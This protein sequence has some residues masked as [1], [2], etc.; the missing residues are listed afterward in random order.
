M[1]GLYFPVFI[2]LSEKRIL[3][4]GGGKVAQRRVETLLAFTPN[5]VVAAPKITAE[6]QRLAGEGAIVWLKE[7]Y[8]PARLEGIDLVLAATDDA[9]CNEQAVYDCRK[10]GIPVNAAHKKELCD[11]YFPAVVRQGGLVA[12]VTSSG[13]SHKKAREAREGIEKTL[14][15]IEERQERG[16]RYGGRE[17]KGNFRRQQG[18]QAGCNSDE[19]DNRDHKKIS[20]GACDSNDYNGDDRGQEA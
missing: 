15:K 14:A 9:R 4:I 18:K 12:G 5:I 19:Y 16:S 1:N 17:K 10:R 11:F 8:C 13:L 7:T 3:V 2:D 6:L 20:S